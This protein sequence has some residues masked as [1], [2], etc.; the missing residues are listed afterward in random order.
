MNYY[1]TAITEEG[2]EIL[3]GDGLRHPYRFYHAAIDAVY[4][5]WTDR[6]WRRR[7]AGFKEKGTRYYGDGGT[8]HSSG[9]IDV[10]TCNGK[11]VAV[12]FRCQQLPFKQAEIEKRSAK[13]KK[14]MTER[15][16]LSLHGVEVRELRDL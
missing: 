11:V 15:L 7:Q 1:S 13:E 12:W 14:G 10:E 9:H 6:H 8:I 3:R 4:H 2:K 16:K 5:W